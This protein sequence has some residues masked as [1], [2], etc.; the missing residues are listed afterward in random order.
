MPKKKSKRESQ[1]NKKS[2][3]NKKNHKSSKNCKSNKKCSNNKNNKN[4]KSNQNN[5]GIASLSYAE[6]VVLSATL[7]YSI[8]EEMDEDDL[9]IFLVFLGLLLAEFEVI[10]TQRALAGR[11]TGTTFE[12]ENIVEEEDI[13]LE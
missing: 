1:D 8:V 5:K 4:S 12:D 11:S 2:Q 10:V 6:L 7:A 9:T 13:D 3:G